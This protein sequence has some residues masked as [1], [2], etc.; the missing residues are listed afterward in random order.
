MTNG[1][2]F[3]KKISMHG[4]GHC[5]RRIAY[6][7]IT[8]PGISALAE[9]VE[10][11]ENPR[12]WDGHIHEALVKL[13]LS[14]RGVEFLVGLKQEASVVDEALGIVG[15]VDGVVDV[16]NLTVG[17]RNIPDGRYLLEV[18]SASSGS[19][20]EFAKNGYMATNPAYYAQIQMYLNGTMGE[21][22]DS[23][24]RIDS[25]DVE[26]SMILNSIYSAM[27]VVDHPEYLNGVPDKALILI[28]NKE[29]GEIYSSVITKDPAYYEEL[30]DR[31]TS[32]QKDVESN[33]LPSRL[34]NSPD[35]YECKRCPY[36]TECWS[37]VVTMAK[38]T[39]ITNTSAL[40]LAEDYVRVSKEVK[41][42]SDE[43]ETIKTK[44]EELA[45]DDDKVVIGD[46]VITKVVTTRKTVD[47]DRV[48]R[49]GINVYNEN[50][51]ISRRIS[52]AK[53]R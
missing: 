51:T 49:L 37:G 25:M 34:H 1:E 48:D 42:K 3:K 35:N 9:M 17:K 14:E 21:I 27:P 40:Q 52:L 4:I 47:K 20:W 16:T 46:V 29:S 18:K 39:E 45:G 41:E 22:E 8:D 10:K 15:H 24:K 7:L 30:V 23:A 50:T 31:W 2:Q 13:Y 38:P 12:F 19:W 26:R 5:P 32:A 53:K 6:P 36:L 43:L 44:L 33:T 28:K 11:V